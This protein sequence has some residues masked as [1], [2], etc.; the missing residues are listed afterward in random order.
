[1]PLL[2]EIVR[3]Q[4]VVLQTQENEKAVTAYIPITSYITYR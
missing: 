1:M 4:S 3:F 2:E